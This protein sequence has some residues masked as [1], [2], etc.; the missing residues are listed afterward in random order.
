MVSRPAVKPILFSAPIVQALLD[1]RKTQTRRVMKPQPE[2]SFVCHDGNVSAEMLN[3]SVTAFFK[4]ENRMPAKTGDL[5]WVRETFA[6]VGGGDPGFLLYRAGDY[7]KQCDKYRFDKP[8]PPV[9]AVKWTPSIFMPRSASRLTLCVTDV[10][11]ER[12][13]DINESDALAEGVVPVGA[14][15]EDRNFSICPT[16][17]GTGIHDDIDQR[18]GCVILDVDCRDCDTHKQRFKHLWNSINGHDAWDDNPWVW[19]YEFE[20]I[21]KNVGEVEG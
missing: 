18:S 7:E 11:A 17:G 21:E 10:R 15:V 20:V 4:A 2:V 3:A 6:Y 19:V 9:S 14:E 1:G 13:Q 16:C 5:L 8:Y 12:L